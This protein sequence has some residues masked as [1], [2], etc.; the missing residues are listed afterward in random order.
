LTF[1]EVFFG[2]LGMLD[3]QA[4]P[5]AIQPLKLQSEGF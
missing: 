2:E 4:F 1:P 5:D 3:P